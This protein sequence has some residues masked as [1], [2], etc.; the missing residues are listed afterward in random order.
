MA[1]TNCPKC[2]AGKDKLVYVQKTTEYW[3]IEAINEDGSVD[4]GELIESHP[5]DDER[6]E[7]EAC[8][9]RFQVCGDIE[10]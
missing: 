9:H 2:G 5:A 6:L 8:G 10:Q 1:L 7:C 3:S 4:L